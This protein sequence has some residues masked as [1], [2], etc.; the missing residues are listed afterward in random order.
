VSHLV[1]SDEGTLHIGTFMA[2]LGMSLGPV[3][4][5]TLV[6]EVGRLPAMDVGT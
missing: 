4:P 2:G 6:E 3:L 1:T 5:D